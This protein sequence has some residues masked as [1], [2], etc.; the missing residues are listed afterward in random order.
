VSSARL[1]LDEI[2]R[3]LHMGAQMTDRS[4]LSQNPAAEYVD[5]GLLVP[6]AKNPRKNDHVVERLAESIRRF[7]FGA[8]IIARSGT[9]EVIAGHTRLKAAKALGM[10]KVPVRYL[11]LSEGEAHALALAD[12]KLTEGADWDN[13][14][15]GE[16]LAELDADGVDTS[17]LG[18]DSAEI[19]ALLDEPLADEGATGEDDAPEVDDGPVDSTAGT[20]Y[21]LGPHRL[22]CGDCR[23]P[24]DVARLLDGARI[25]IA[26]TSPPYA[27]QR[28][29]DPSSGF[30]PI[31][32]DEFVDWFEAVQANVRANLAED[33]SW[34]VN[35]KEHCEDGQRHLYVKDLTIAHV[36]RWGW[37]FVD[38]L[39]WYKQGMPGLFGERLKNEYEPVFHFAGGEAKTRFDAVKHSSP[40]VPTGSKGT[41]SALQGVED[42]FLGRS[43]GMALPGNVIRCPPDSAGVG[44]HAARFPVALPEFFIKAYTDPGDVV[45]EPFCGS[46]TTLIAAAKHKRI[47]FGMEISPRYCDVIRRRWTRYAKE[48][49]IDPGPGALEDRDGGEG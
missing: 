48:N 32:P 47:A 25:N 9:R 12:N 31:R 13:E 5:I 26:F 7:G 45:F 42:P 41:S 4:D 49:G 30:K 38:E 16:V 17:G 19:N 18:W 36:R 35:I 33:G 27:S 1:T 14:M 2:R 22:L 29:Y 15:L 40:K 28:E 21:H 46:G 43:E 24:E 3:L 34:F 20:L 39:I 10:A 37:R 11:E 23:K 6:W 8:P 44:A